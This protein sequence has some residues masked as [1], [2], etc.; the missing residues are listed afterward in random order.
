MP[1]SFRLEKDEGLLDWTGDEGI[2]LDDQQAMVIA[3]AEIGGALREIALALHQFNEAFADNAQ[4]LADG[5]TSR[6]APSTSES[7]IGAVH[8]RPRR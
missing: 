6:S 2:D 8:L 3:V 1:V 7:A 5:V 4:R